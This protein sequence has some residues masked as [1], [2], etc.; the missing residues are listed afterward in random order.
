[1]S[2]FPSWVWIPPAGSYTSIT[3]AVTLRAYRRPPREQAPCRGGGR[4]RNTAGSPQGQEP[5]WHS[6]TW[7]GIQPRGDRVAFWLTPI[8]WVTWTRRARAPQPALPPRPNWVAER[9]R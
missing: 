7:R 6:V 4:A 9:S 8:G 1:M 2:R 3:P 5:P